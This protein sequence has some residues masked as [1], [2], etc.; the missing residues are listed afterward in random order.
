MKSSHYTY[1]LF[2]GLESKILRKVK[3]LQLAKLLSI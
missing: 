3:E 1:P 2:K